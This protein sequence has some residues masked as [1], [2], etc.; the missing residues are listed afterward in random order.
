M[1]SR[2]FNAYPT[3]SSLLPKITPSF[4][5]Y[6]GFSVPANVAK[7]PQPPQ[8]PTASPPQFSCPSDPP[9]PP[10]SFP[11]TFELPSP[12]FLASSPDAFYLPLYILDDNT[13]PASEIGVVFFNVG[14]FSVEQENEFVFRIKHDFVGSDIKVNVFGLSP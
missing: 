11:I 9:P 12:F 13:T 5:S 8:D 1:D 7:I 10:F 2:V 6:I 14:L 3:R 4:H